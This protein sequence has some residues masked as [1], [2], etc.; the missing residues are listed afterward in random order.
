LAAKVQEDALRR[1]EAA[2]AEKKIDD[3][4]QFVNRFKGKAT[5]ARQAQSKVKQI[6]RLA[7]DI[8]TPVYSSRAWPSLSF[9]SCRSS[10]K[11]VL[12]VE[13]ISEIN[14]FIKSA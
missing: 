14:Y 8:E 4:Q 3:L 12:E 7:R 6:E 2:K 10:G 9:K 1:Q 5:K 13:G 11:T